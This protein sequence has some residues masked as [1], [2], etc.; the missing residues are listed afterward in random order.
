MNNW[1]KIGREDYELQTSNMVHIVNESEQ[2]DK[3]YVSL[4]F[5]IL[6]IQTDPEAISRLGKTEPGKNIQ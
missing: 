6:G 5:R 4:L 3:D 2:D 1:P